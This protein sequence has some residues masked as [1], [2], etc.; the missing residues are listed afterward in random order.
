MA[1]T[2]TVVLSPSAAAVSSGSTMPT[3]AS[4]PPT[5]HGFSTPHSTQPAGNTGSS[6]LPANAST[7]TNTTSSPLGQ[8]VSSHGASGTTT[9]QPATGPA[10]ARPPAQAG[11]RF[12]QSPTLGNILGAVVL[13]LTVIGL[14]W[15]FGVGVVGLNLQKW[16]ARN[17]ALQSCLSWKD[18]GHTSSYCSH[19]IEVGVTRPPVL[20]RALSLAYSSIRPSREYDRFPV[21]QYAAVVTTTL[22]AGIFTLIYFRPRMAAFRPVISLVRM[23]PPQLIVEW[24]TATTWLPLTVR[25]VLSTHP[26]FGLLDDGTNQHAFIY[27]PTIPN[28]YDSGQRIGVFYDSEG[29]SDGQEDD[30]Q[31]SLNGFQN[32]LAVELFPDH[33]PSSA[34]TSEAISIATLHKLQ[35]YHA[36]L[37][38]WFWKQEV[39]DVSLESE[40]REHSTRLAEV[41]VDDFVHLTTQ[42]CQQ[43]SDARIQ[44]DNNWDA[45]WHG[46][47]EPMIQAA[48]DH[49]Y[50][51]SVIRQ[52]AQRL[53]KEDNKQALQHSAN[54]E[55]SPQDWDSLIAKWHSLVDELKLLRT[56]VRKKIT[57]P[58]NLQPEPLNIM[59]RISAD[60]KI[61][62]NLAERAKHDR[63]WPGQ[64]HLV[65]LACDRMLGLPVHCSWTLEHQDFVHQRLG[66][67]ALLHV[68]V[69]AQHLR[70]RTT[71][72]LLAVTKPNT[73]REVCRQS[74][75]ERVAALSESMHAHHDAEEATVK[76]RIP[77]FS[78]EF[79]MP[80]KWAHEIDSY[81][82]ERLQ[83]SR[84]LL[85]KRISELCSRAA[86]L[87]D[88]LSEEGI[89]FAAEHLAKTFTSLRDIP[90]LRGNVPSLCLCLAHAGIPEGRR[91]DIAKCRRE[92]EVLYCLVP[93]LYRIEWQARND[94][95]RALSLLGRREQL[96]SE[97]ESPLASGPSKDD[98]QQHPRSSSADFTLETCFAR[99]HFEASETRTWSDEDL[100]DMYDGTDKEVV[101]NAHTIMLNE[102]PVSQD[103]PGRR[104]RAI[105]IVQ[106]LF[107]R[108]QQKAPVYPEV[109]WLYDPPAEM[110]QA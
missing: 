61:A 74:D 54:D 80:I 16:T 31:S 66:R 108:K 48:V 83:T 3:V 104:K 41:P 97:A 5:G 60:L 63:D 73:F 58:S 9:A 105:G 49:A 10:N 25:R 96:S 15:A 76:R 100:R 79:R 39:D 57:F 34:E 28:E 55:G 85:L 90:I 93:C 27:G 45:E 109:A 84:I 71:D 6:A 2:A 26:E 18:S 17:D 46:V 33:L 86:G 44:S 107:R 103:Q 24:F 47:A 77:D 65:S 51:W 36:F 12:I 88:H 59:A 110:D 11:V 91:K 101:P 81:R 89:W 20:K 40:S 29:E 94:L 95:E 92:I 38:D 62:I 50:V 56:Q 102:P 35:D 19:I 4:A 98:Q 82:Y 37:M 32:G 99:G 87:S 8:V 67:D 21:Y 43:I 7:M 1:N 64:N 42:L 22:C 70:Q 53:R 30:L 78:W 69:C 13:V 52:I 68:L 75:S 106:G 14:G 72:A 23:Q